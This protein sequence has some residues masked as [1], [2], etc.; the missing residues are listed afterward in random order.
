LLQKAER[1]SRA[2]RALGDVRGTH[3]AVL[4]DVRQTDFRTLR[5]APRRGFDAVITSPPYETALPYIDTQRLS[6]V[7]LGDVHADEVQATEK[8]LIGARE[9]STRERR[10]LES[11]I[12]A[13]DSGLPPTVVSLCRQLLEDSRRPGNGFRRV[14]RPALTF[15][16]FKF[17][18]AFMRK[19]RN[20]V[21]PGGSIALVVGG[22]RTQLGG[23]E[24]EID[25]PQLL[26]DLA[27]KLGYGVDDLR[28]KD[29]Y[30]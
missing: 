11:A 8:A 7:V 13:G 23:R 9:I 6:L 20:A 10:E 1:V 29:A 25:A 22:N 19:L 3:V 28:P 14:N 30:F 16:Y 21:R 17:M 2:R 4:G 5:V 15:R 18:G 27:Q 26:A 12:A 24:Y